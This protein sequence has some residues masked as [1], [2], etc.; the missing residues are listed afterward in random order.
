MSYDFKLEI[1]TGGEYPAPVTETRSPTYNLAEIFD[2]ALG[3]SVRD[4]RGKSG[5]ECAPLLDAAL[6]RMKK[7]PAV[8]KKLNPSNG[9]GTYED[10][11]SSFHWLHEVCLEHPKALVNV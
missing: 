10:A 2:K 11:L 4:L 7:S 5:A 8:Y 9:W 6:V 3:F 1:D